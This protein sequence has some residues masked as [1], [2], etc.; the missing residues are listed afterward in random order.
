MGYIY[1]NL[2]AGSYYMEKSIITVLVMV[3]GGR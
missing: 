1:K 3:A 2:Q